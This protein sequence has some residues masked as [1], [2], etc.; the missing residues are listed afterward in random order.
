MYV[1]ITYRNP[2]K[3]IICIFGSQNKPF[4]QFLS[5]QVQWNHGTIIITWYFKEICW[6]LGFR[7]ERKKIFEGKCYLERKKNVFMHL[8]HGMN[9]VANIAKIVVLKIVNNISIVK[10]L[11]PNSFF[12]YL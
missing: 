5:R 4:I 12:F 10:Q 1:Q 9:I 2:K 3:W 7:E 11:G 6:G 8:S